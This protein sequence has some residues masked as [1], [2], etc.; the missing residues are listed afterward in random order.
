M[1][2]AGWILPGQAELRN[3]ENVFASLR[4]R[5][6]RQ[7][8]KDRSKASPSVNS[9]KILPKSYETGE[10]FGH[11]LAYL[12]V[13]AFL[14][15]LL[16]RVFLQD[17]VSPVSRLSSTTPPGPQSGTFFPNLCPV[18]PSVPDLSFGKTRLNYP[19]IKT[20]LYLSV[21]A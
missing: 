14:A 9:G 4:A 13:F 12:A 2:Y 5:K 7:A 16:S 17:P 3:K 18:L 19:E 10:R 6:T 20:N 21:V 15:L 8:R 1:K 11:H